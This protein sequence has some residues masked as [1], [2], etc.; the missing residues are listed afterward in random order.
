MQDMTLLERVYALEK[1]GK[2]NIARFSPDRL[3]RSIMRHLTAMLNTRRG[4]VPIAPDYGIA[5]LTDLG[6]GFTKEG[7]SD[8]EAELARVILRYEPRL[9]DVRV[10]Y[11]PRPDLPL[12]AV[13][14]IDAI[15]QTE[16]GPSPLQLETILDATGIVRLQEEDS[17]REQAG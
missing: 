6:S 7:V 14:R 8:L 13:F 1:E 5:D 17:F 16:N 9:R 2:D 10:T 4:N 15:C 3:R 11:A 12:A